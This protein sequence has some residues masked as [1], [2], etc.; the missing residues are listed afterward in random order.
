MV[1]VHLTSDIINMLIIIMCAK[2]CHIGPL[3]VHRHWNAACIT[4]GS[5][6]LYCIY[7]IL[8]IHAQSSGA[9]SWDQY[10]RKECTLTLQQ[11]LLHLALGLVLAQGDSGLVNCTEGEYV[12][13]I[14]SSETRIH[15]QIILNLL[16]LISRMIKPCIRFSMYKHVCTLHCN[17]EHSKV[18]PT[19][20]Y[21]INLI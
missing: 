12:H 19:S 16:P 4:S 21:M 13:N 7:T 5:D 2:I 1:L 3:L 18:E 15:K 8:H 6:K 20:V 17:F 10:F 14:I 9:M 11:S